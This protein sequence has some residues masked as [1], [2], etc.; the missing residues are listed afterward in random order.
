MKR[1]RLHQKLASCHVFY[2]Q[3]R[4]PP[5]KGSHNQLIWN[6]NRQQLQNR[7]SHDNHTRENWTTFGD[8]IMLLILRKR[9]MQWCLK[10]WLKLGILE[11]SQRPLMFQNAVYLGSS[12]S[13]RTE[14][15]CVRVKKRDRNTFCWWP[16][17][18]IMAAVNAKISMPSVCAMGNYCSPALI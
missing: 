7:A 11:G 16:Q 12:L 18:K 1:I 4:L 3:H 13:F 17:H 10:I 9:T 6:A 14:L 5:F 15:I 2:C 8:I